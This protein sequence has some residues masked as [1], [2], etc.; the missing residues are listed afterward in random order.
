MHG[1][2]VCAAWAAA[3]KTADYVVYERHGRWVYASGSRASIIL[4][5]SDVRTVTAEGVRVAPWSG[6]PA[7]AL[8]AAFA[9]LGLTDWRAY[10][11]LGFDF[12]APSLGV[13]EHV[14]ASSVLAHLLVPEFEAWVGSDG[15]SFAGAD[16]E[17]E[18][19]LTELAASVPDES[20]RT[21]AVDVDVDDTGFRDTV[22]QAISEIRSGRYEKVI[23][24]RKIIVPFEVDLPRTYVQGRMSNSPARSFLIRIGGLEAAGFSPELVGS[25]DADRTLIAE[26]LAGTR[27]FGRSPEL[28]LI[29]REDLLSDAK[30]IAEHAVS[31][32]TAFSEVDG[33]AT[34]GTTAV[35]TFMVVRERGSVQHLASTVRGTLAND[36]GPWD[37]IEAVFPAVTASGVPKSEAVEA[38]YRLEG[39]ARGLYSGAVVTASSNGEVEAALALRTVFREDGT[40]WI[41]AGAG[42]VAQSNPDREFEET[43]EKLA[44]VAPHLVERTVSE[45]SNK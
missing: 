26:P 6:R 22:A 29:A 43:C 4:R 40:A 27:A 5:R 28:D 10:G 34:Q 13:A 17:T 41:R 35:T 7:L 16:S 9:E 31:V 36:A 39:N 44:S 32:R 1:A 2:R 38:I 11:W 37:G 19:R 14:D 18:R 42:I 23:L 21:R 15:I 8:A 20:V 3:E 30:E 25:V 45:R 24:S 12:G 33:V